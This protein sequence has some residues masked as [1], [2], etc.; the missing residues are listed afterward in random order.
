MCGTDT[1]RPGIPVAEKLRPV[2]VDGRGY[3][4]EKAL[5]IVH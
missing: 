3:G 1:A 5:P 2:E 4:G